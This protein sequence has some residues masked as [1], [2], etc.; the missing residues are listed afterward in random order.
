MSRKLKN[1]II[2]SISTVGS[3]VLGLLRDVLM[4]ALFGIANANSA[5]I[6][7]FTMPNLF[8]RLLG[9]GALTSALIPVFSHEM[10]KNDGK[11]GAF[12]FLN[13]TLSWTFLLLLTLSLLGIYGA[14]LV[15]KLPGLENRYY[16]GAK[17]LML[18]L[19]YMIFICLAALLAAILNVLERFKTAA[20]SQIWLNF[21]MIFALII[22][23]SLY[24]KDANKIALCLCA[25][26]LCG[27]FLQ[28]TIP[29]VRMMKL[30]WR[31]AFDFRISQPIKDLLR[32]LLPGLAGASIFQ[33]NIAVSRTLAFS[34]GD[35]EVSILYLANRLIELPL[36]VFAISVSTVVFPIMSRLAVKNDYKTFIEEYSKGL[37]MIFMIILPA[38]MGLIVLSEPIL[39]VLFEWG[40]FSSAD[41]RATQPILIISALGLP[42]YGM[43][44]LSTRGLHS[45]K[46]MKT[47]YKVALQSFFINFIL[48]LA[49][50]K[51]WGIQGLASA[52]V[53]SAA[54]Q[55]LILHIRLKS[56]INEA[57]EVKIITN[58][59][60]I[61]LATI[62]MGLF[63]Y[64]FWSMSYGIGEISK[65]K[66]LI[67]VSI[68]IGLGV[69]VYF[70]IIWILGVNEKEMFKHLF[71]ANKS[72]K[73]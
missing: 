31:P 40:Y 36:G 14:S 4:F 67:R 6:L 12:R 55:A 46:D 69:S 13:Q 23:G 3:R 44:G 45:L 33:I 21:T 26:V 47:P 15:E 50:M 34:L 28:V 72:G 30:G 2:V 11:T 18:L 8:R 32:I 7:A 43:S 52:N 73:N 20:L 25:G 70:L 51:Q 61:A 71:I 1:I 5:F 56:K 39:R 64:Y 58:L 59:I 17:Y 54:F 10:E 22:G 63:C 35:Q 16:L 38:A 49:F 37:S 53:I 27:G 60:K 24:P 41:V 19:P 65:I 42:F 62:S 66:E 57:N 48:S 29:V 68:T 9:E